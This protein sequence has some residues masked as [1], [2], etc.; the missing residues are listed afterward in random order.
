[1]KP[2][3]LCAVLSL[4]APATAMAADITAPRLDGS[5]TFD[6]HLKE[7]MWQTAAR[8]PHTQF[9]RWVGNSYDSEQAVF[10]LR[11]FHDGHSLFVALVS[12][13]RYVE[14]DAS[15]ENADGLYSLSIATRTGKLRHHRLRWSQNPPLA[16]GDMPHYHQWGARLRG[17]FQQPGHPGGGYVFEFAI[18]LWSTGW[19]PGDS[20]PLNIIVTDHNGKPGGSY[21]GAG[22]EFARFAFGSFDNDDRAAYQ[23]LKLAR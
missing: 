12:Y 11:F 17:P 22:V 14:A 23:T 20:L 5:V 13:D 6:G 18:P 21:R 9:T 1:M 2:W 7:P 8:L 19:R 16:G 3:L 4:I 15:P 10:H